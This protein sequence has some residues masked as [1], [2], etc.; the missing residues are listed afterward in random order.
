MASRNNGIWRL[1]E[2]IDSMIAFKAWKMRGKWESR[3]RGASSR[4]QYLIISTWEDGPSS[5]SCSPCE[6][7]SRS[8]IHDMVRSIQP[9]FM[10]FQALTGNIW[11]RQKYICFDT[12]GE[13]GGANIGRHHDH[14]DC[15]MVQ[16]CQIDV[17]TLNREVWFFMVSFIV[18]ILQVQN[19]GHHNAP[20][21]SGLQ[22]NY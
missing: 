10:L 19:N 4:L 8:I 11:A 17:R 21:V 12:E 7:E 5:Q 13:N 22:Q 6:E 9:C 1:Y 20:K 14:L 18:I 2:F 16:A 15:Q 3:I